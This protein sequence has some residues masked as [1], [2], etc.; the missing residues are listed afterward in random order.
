MEDAECDRYVPVTH[1]GFYPDHQSETGTYQ[2]QNRLLNILSINVE[3][4]DY[5]GY[6]FDTS[7]TIQG[8]DYNNCLYRNSTDSIGIRWQIAIDRY[9]GIVLFSKRDEYRW[10][11]VLEW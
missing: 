2:Q 9:Y 4:Q 5:L 7:L 8:F 6:G 1:F 11:R 10:E 3:L